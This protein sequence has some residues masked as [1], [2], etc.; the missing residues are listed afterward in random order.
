M[1]D[2]I[3][4]PELKRLAAEAIAAGCYRDKAALLVAGLDLV[5]RLEAERAAFV[6]SLEAAEADTEQN[7]TLSLDDIMVDVDRIIEAAERQDA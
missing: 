3:L 7:G 6:A 1:D 4:S 5:R 2:M